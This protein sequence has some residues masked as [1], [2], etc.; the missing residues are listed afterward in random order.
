M[1]WADLTAAA[2]AATAASGGGGA[3]PVARCG[4]GFAAG[5]DG[6]LYVHAGA[7]DL[8]GEWASANQ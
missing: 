6:R 7:V 8:S 4:H 3:P 5:A 1:A 2:A